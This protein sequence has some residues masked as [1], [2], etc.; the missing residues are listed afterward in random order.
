MGLLRVLLAYPVALTVYHESRVWAELLCVLVSQHPTSTAPFPG[1]AGLPCLHNCTLLVLFPLWV[2]QLFV[3]IPHFCVPALLLL[4]YVIRAGSGWGLYVCARRSA[5]SLSWAALH[6]RT[7]TLA[8][9]APSPCRA[10][11][12]VHSS[13]PLTPQ[14]AA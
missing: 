7:T 1:G 5:F 14:G 12:R 13:T 11:L 2:V 6:M 4:L 10:A 3:L 9:S 8:S